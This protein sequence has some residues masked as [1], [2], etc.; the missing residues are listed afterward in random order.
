MGERYWK[1]GAMRSV[2]VEQEQDV[3]MAEA[4]AEP[5]SEDEVRFLLPTSVDYA[6]LSVSTARHV[7]S[8]TSNPS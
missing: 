3:N 7:P 8:T 5:S 1:Q 6:D 4:Q 2:L